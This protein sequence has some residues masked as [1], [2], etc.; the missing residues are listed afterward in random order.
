MIRLFFI[1]LLFFFSSS[2]FA[3]NASSREAAWSGCNSA[4][5]GLI[6]PSQASCTE[7]GITPQVSLKNTQGNLLSYY[8]YSKQCENS[9]FSFDSS[10]NICYPAC[11]GTQVLDKASKSCKDDSTPK[12]C[13]DVNATVTNPAPGSFTT[14]Q[15]KVMSS[16]PAPCPEQA[17]LLAGN[18]CNITYCS[19]FQSFGL[20]GAMC[21]PP[22]VCPEHSHHYDPYTCE[23]DQPVDCA[24]QNAHV[25]NTDAYTCAPDDP[26]SCPANQHNI[27]D[28]ACGPDDPLPCGVHE[29]NPPGDPYSCV[30]DPPVNCPA[31]THAVGQYDC[32]QDPTDP[33]P[34]TGG[35]NSGGPG[36]GGGSNPGDT[37][38][39]GGSGTGTGTGTGTPGDGKC[40]DPPVC[41]T[42]ADP[43]QCAIMKS[44]YAGSCQPDELTQEAVDEA[45]GGITQQDADEVGLAQ[46]DSS[47]LGFSNS[48][49]APR[50]FGVGATSITIDYDPFCDL[51]S[52]FGYLFMITASFVSLRILAS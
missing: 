7:N 32:E 20:P 29:H 4:R 51:A 24:A 38:S 9:S 21:P 28:Y 48:C 27:S 18:Y 40:A 50:S 14:C 43:V 52:V 33:P 42:N 49:P 6:N 30:P 13:I 11:S 15:Y 39:P 46:L 36:G 45:M 26:I 23:P 12:V 8:S 10:D 22:T 25:H 2:V 37:G 16:P 3:I 41:P 47:G 17:V 44:T 1:F 19:G 31:G 5:S 35:G 34:D